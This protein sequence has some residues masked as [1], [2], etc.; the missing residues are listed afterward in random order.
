M[1]TKTLTQSPSG[2]YVVVE[3]VLTLE[4]GKTKPVIV[5]TVAFTKDSTEEMF[6]YMIQRNSV[7]RSDLEYALSQFEESGHNTAE[8]GIFGGLCF[9]MYK[10]ALH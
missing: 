3:K 4:N 1:R 5:S 6:Q 7:S 10:G 9:T 8:F 2:H